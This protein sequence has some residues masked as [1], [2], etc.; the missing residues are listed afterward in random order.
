MKIGMRAARLGLLG[1]STALALLAAASVAAQ[2][3]TVGK[4]TAQATP[5]SAQTTTQPSQP[6]P[7]T[8]SDLPADPNVRFGTLPN[9]MRYA[10]LHNATPPQ[11]ASLWLRVDA[12]SL[13]EKDDQL[14][15]AHFM[16][17]MAFNGTTHIPKNEVITLLERLGLQF[18]ADLNAAT[19][20]DQT[21]YR[22]DLPHSDD[23]TL[24]TGLFV[25]REQVSEATMD[26][27]DIVDERGVI[28]GEERLRNV[29]SLRV[30]RK[31]LDILAKDQKVADRFPIGDLKIINTA[32]RDRFVDFYNSYYRPSRATVV[33]VGDFDVDA[34]EKR[35][36]AKF[37]DWTPKA[38]DGPN[39]DLGKVASHALE[40]HV[41]VEPGISS[42]V[43]LLWPVAPKLLPDTA[44]NR[45]DKIVRELALAVLDRRFGEMSRSDNP[46]FVSASSGESDIFRSVHVTTVGAQF[47]P[48][49]WKR[50][51]ETVDQEQRRLV[52]FGI[53]DDE[54][55]REINSRRTRL[56]NEVKSA[57]T[58]N[59]PLLASNIVSSVNDR[60]VFTSPQEDLAIF[61]ASVKGLTAAQVNKRIPAIFAGEGPIVAVS[62][63]TPIEGGEQALAAAYSA[64]RQLAVSAPAGQ[65]KL[66]WPY[67]NFGA[68]GQVVSRQE[69]ADLGA[70]VLRFANGVTV[71]VKPTKFADNQIIVK[72]LTG[73]GERNFSPDTF[74][75]RSTLFGNLEPGGLSKMTTD[76][77]SRSLNGHNVGMAPSTL[78][79]KFLLSGGTTPD[80]LQLEMQLLAAYVTD[81]AFR[82][83]AFL[84]IQANYPAVYEAAL[85]LPA[86]AFSTYTKTLLAGGDKRTWVLKPEEVAKI[87]PEAYRS[88]L[89]DLLSQGPIHITMV[90]DLSVDDA[91]RVVS[92]TFGALPPRRDLA[93]QPAGADLRRFPAPT[94]TPLIFTHKGLAEQGLGYLAWPTTDSVGDL[95][96]GRKIE[97]LA[98]V[99]KLRVL[100]EIRERLAIAYSPSVSSFYSDGYKGYGVLS[101]TAQ[102]APD[103]LPA[104]YD[105]M[106]RIVSDL[107]SKP[108][109]M[110]ELNRARR[111]MIESASR[112]QNN[113]YWWAD[114]LAYV[115]DRP[116]YAPQVLTFNSTLESLTPTD[117]QMLAQKYLRMDKAWKAEVVPAGFDTGTKVISAAVTARSDTSKQ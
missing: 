27:E 105:A 93:P 106:D 73:Q 83:G 54:L 12:G 1:G 102:T 56:E 37:G 117:V 50:A 92:S 81:P 84:R 67:T 10:I 6:W 89:K 98:A 15:L 49:K 36:R 82:P 108:I 75:P 107:R 33:A 34:M 31:M 23:K 77:I 86:G 16:E 19:S 116:W 115:V 62:P 48:G 46:P 20:F 40:S 114:N 79:D 61:E 90:G 28:A 30:G 63:P 3:G 64:S 112:A 70:T 59:T 74:D 113:N 69:L 47:V 58:R 53:S 24:D 68:G 65:P 111:P 72:V 35:I 43:S 44:A 78:S 41:I 66:P 39:P 9:G 110:D 42:S 60:E 80:D 109:G 101:A 57:S 55:T 94:P 95:T 38:P 25:L 2:D 99:L 97:L 52:Q 32:P 26:P 45:Q 91:I 8:A 88:Q 85:A 100:D 13:M 104:F 7:Q 4:P 96:E 51:V 71:T 18:G 11:Q 21:F 87:D 17:H 22:L 29:P 103:K 14:G 76:Q 5:T